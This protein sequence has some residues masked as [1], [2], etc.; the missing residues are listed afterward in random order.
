M[1]W[2]ESLRDNSASEVTVFY[3]K[4][5]YQFFPCRL[6]QEISLTQRKGVTFGDRA[7]LKKKLL[8]LLDFFGDKGKD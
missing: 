7:F 5:K 4:M 6:T 8:A 2:S 1:K 3:T